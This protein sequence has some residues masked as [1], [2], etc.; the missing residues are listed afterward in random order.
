MKR[1]LTKIAVFLIALLAVAF[2]ADRSLTQFFKKGHIVKAQWQEHMHDQQYDVAIIGSS[3][4]WWNIDMNVI[5]A[6]CGVRAVSLANNHFLPSEVLLS[7]KI[8][9]ANGNTAK[10]ILMQVDHDNLSTE[11]EEFSSTAYDFVPY[12]HDSIVYD[13]FGPRSIEWKAMRYIPFW[14]YTMVNFKW[15]VEQVLTQGRRKPLFDSTGTYFSNPKFYGDTAIMIRPGG[16][17][18]GPDI[19]EIIEL[20]AQHHIQLDFFMAPYFNLIAPQEVR[21]GPANALKAEGFTLHD[22]SM[23]LT[24]KRLFNDTK[25]INIEGGKV[26][27]GILA[28]ELVCPVSVTSIV[29]SES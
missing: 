22:Y 28:R 6:Q 19:K 8:F 18:V 2:V 29:D 20:C 23:R 7:L 12:L 15:G 21:N 26:F 1:F 3:R 27:T 16:Y 10:R 24:E 4:G 14:R 5:D 9:L 25:H 17:E 11:A 13:H